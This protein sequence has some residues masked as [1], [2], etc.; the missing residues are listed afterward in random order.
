MIAAK[1]PV[2]V[3]HTHYGAD[4][5]KCFVEVTAAPVLDE[6][7][8]VSYIIETCCDVTE[9]MRLERRSA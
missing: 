5:K 7:G 4:G 1:I 2:T 6:A 9:R 8:E 3:M